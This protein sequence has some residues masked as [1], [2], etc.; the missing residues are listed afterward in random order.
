MKPR[1]LYAATF[2][3]LSLSGGRF[4]ATFMEHELQFSENWMIGGAM[5]LQILAHSLMSS[6]FGTVADSWEASRSIGGDAGSNAD[7]SEIFAKFIFLRKGRMLMMICGLSLSACSIL[8]HI[9]GT[10]WMSW[11]STGVEDNSPLPDVILVYHLVLRAFYAMGIA[12]CI[13]VL[14]GLTL[15][16]LEEEG[17]ESAD[18]GKER[19]YGALSWG[20][21]HIFF[22]PAIDH[23]GFKTIYATT[24]LSFFSCCA[25]FY[26]YAKSL[27]KC[28]RN[29]CEGMYDGLSDIRDASQQFDN[30]EP[31]GLEMGVTNDEINKAKKD[32]QLV[33]V[34]PLSCKECNVDDFHENEMS[35][36]IFNNESSHENHQQLKPTLALLLRILFQQK[37]PLLNF[38]YVVALFT[39]YIGMSVVENLIF[40]Y[41]EF[42]GGSYTLCGLTVMVTVIFELP[43]FHY[44]PKILAIASPVWMFQ[45]GCL[46]YIVRTVGYSFVP[47]S[48]PYLVLFLE[49]LHGVT[50]GF[51][52][53]GSVAFA[54][55]WVPKG[56]EASGQGFLSLIMGM[57][58]FLG[59]CTGMFLEGRVLY[60]VLAG[61]VSAGSIILAIGQHVT[62]KQSQ[63]IQQESESTGEDVLNN[64][65]CKAEQTSEAKITCTNVPNTVR[66]KLG[67]NR[68]Q[69]AKYNRLSYKTKQSF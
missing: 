12:A 6:W 59:L 21:A 60:R 25:V 51:V 45:C 28:G 64:E 20:L 66:S 30:N 49:P 13:P 26:F 39:L 5:A 27:S 68:G 31:T 47:R 48:H 53:T 2:T 33:S 69:H 16:Q 65:R 3:F 23:F 32:R 44:A 19:V 29:S 43:I 67:L 62:T 40:I 56:Y 37:S 35:S 8:L 36:D 4:S 38:S 46:A 9:P 58:Q 1:I 41:F 61:I 11:K 24:I 57:G 34:E 50:I 10:L 54:D 17:R 14:D 55:T 63:S 42:L 18:Y 15:A 22:G 7:S 52:K